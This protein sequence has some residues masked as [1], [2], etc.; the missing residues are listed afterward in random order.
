MKTLTYNLMFKKG[1]VFIWV[2]LTSVT[3][4]VS[5]P[6][7]TIMCIIIVSSITMTTTITTSISNSSSSSIAY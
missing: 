7:I 4:L 3:I 1:M 2:G 6:E 5:P